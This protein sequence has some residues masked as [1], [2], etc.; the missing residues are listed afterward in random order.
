MR[1]SGFFASR[2]PALPMRVLTDWAEGVKAPHAGP[3]E[4]AGAL[5]RDRAR[6]GERLHAIGR[7]PEIRGASSIASPDLLDALTSRPGDAGVEAALVR[8]VVRM[9]SRATPFGCSRPGGG[10][11]SGTAP[12]SSCPIPD[13]GAASPS[14]TPTTSMPSSAN[15]LRY[16]ATASPSCRTTA[17]TC[18]GAGGATS[19]PG[20]TGSTGPIT[21]SSWQGRPTCSGP[22]APP[23][24]APPAGRSPTPSPPAGSTRPGRPPTWTAWWQ[25]R[26]S[27]PTSP[28]P[29]RPAAPR[30]PGRRPRSA[31]RRCDCRR[32]S[33]GA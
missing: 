23:A 7:R 30:R 19:N 21:W 2:V 32:A 5:E 3:K 12:R 22:S 27:S 8:Y 15:G 24:R 28:S 16:S 29:S 11:G 4:L 20:S 25:P 14:S 6:L 33:P 10:G 13:H 31:R 9:A 17:S 26:C 18:W 1:S